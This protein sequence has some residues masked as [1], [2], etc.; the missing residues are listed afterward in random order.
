MAIEYRIF[1]PAEA[2]TMQ[3]IEA[4]EQTHYELTLALKANPDNK[5]TAKRIADLEAE[6]EVLAATLPQTST[7]TPFTEA[8]DAQIQEIKNLQIA[9]QVA[10][11]L[12]PLK[13]KDGAIDCDAA[14]AA[15]EDLKNT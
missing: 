1:Q 8:I 6:H 3:R 5:G 2:E 15:L 11:A 14:I 10:A 4:I 7:H 12:E 13:D 9:T